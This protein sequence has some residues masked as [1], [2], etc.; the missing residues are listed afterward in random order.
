MKRIGNLLY[1]GVALATFSAWAVWLVGNLWV[2]AHRPDRMEGIFCLLFVNIP[3]G[4]IMG[5][6]GG[7]GLIAVMEAIRGR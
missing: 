2:V 1:G 5:I 3:I 7:T 6:V 4:M